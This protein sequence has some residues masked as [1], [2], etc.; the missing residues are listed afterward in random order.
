MNRYALS[1]FLIALSTSLAFSEEMPSMDY[2]LTEDAPHQRDI[3]WDAYFTTFGGYNWSIFE[4]GGYN[5]NFEDFSYGARASGAYNFENGVSVQKDLVY[6]RDDWG[7]D[8]DLGFFGNGGVSSTDMD[9][10][11]HIYTQT[12]TY[13]FGAI[14]QIGKTNFDFGVLSQETNRF[15]LGG[16]AQGYFGA[17]TIY[18]QA[19]YEKTKTDGIGF[20]GSGGFSSDGIVA[21]LEGRYFFTDNWRFDVKGAYTF[22]KFD[23]ADLELDAW[24]FSAGTE[25]KFTDTPFSLT[26]DVSWSLQDNEGLVSERMTA[27][28]GIKMNLGAE[29]LKS[30]DRSGATLDPFEAQQPIEAFFGFGPI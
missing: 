12:D 27:L 30:R 22:Q 25:Y 2:Q 3:K 21:S 8:A 9:A 4:D 11:T 23:I 28:V 7:I 10:A 13:L 16:E 15:Y 1:G 29:T 14:G 18:G 5:E 19:G 20:F 24:T 17:F 6:N 26:S